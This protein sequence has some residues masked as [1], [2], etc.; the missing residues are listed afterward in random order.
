MKTGLFFSLL[1]WEWTFG[2]FI[3]YYCWNSLNIL[4]LFID[5]ITLNECIRFCSRFC[6]HMEYSFHKRDILCF[7]F[8]FTFVFLFWMNDSQTIIAIHYIM[9]YLN[10]TSILLIQMIRVNY[11]RITICWLIQIKWAKMSRVCSLWNKMKY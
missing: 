1:L 6:L 7:E 10:Y 2:H 3:H 4:L 5:S 11:E 8:F 9:Y